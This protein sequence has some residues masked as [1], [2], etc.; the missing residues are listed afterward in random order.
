MNFCFR[1][2]SS[3]I[4]SFS[5]NTPLAQLKEAISYNSGNEDRSHC[6]N[7]L[8]L[9]LVGYR[10]FILADIRTGFCRKNT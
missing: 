8:F 2:T 10:V 4:L 9:V 1:S 6:A 3:Q 5:H 7:W